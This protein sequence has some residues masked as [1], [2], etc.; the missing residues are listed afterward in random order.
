MSRSRKRRKALEGRCYLCGAHS[1][2]TKEHIPPR[3]ALGRGA[4]A[5][6]VQSGAQ[7]FG[8]GGSRVY[9]SG[10]HA[11]VL[12]ERCNNRTGALYGTE[13]ARWSAWGRELLRGVRNG[14]LAFPPYVGYP[15]RIAKQIVSTMI[16]SAGADFAERQ[17]RLRRFVLDPECTLGEGEVN[18]SMYLCTTLT[19]RST[20]V[21]AMW[22]PRGGM[23]LLRSQ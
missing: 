23:H 17:P 7:M 19:G 21:A 12:C 15:A 13:F 2:L 6:R 4:V 20:G 8:A 5:V 14:V 10:F 9:Q 16:A 3:S 1:I 11:P 22:T 18:L